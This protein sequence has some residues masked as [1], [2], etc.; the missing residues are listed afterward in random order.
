MSVFEFE[1]DE[2]KNTNFFYYKE[3]TLERANES[4]DPLRA[5]NIILTFLSHADEAFEWKAQ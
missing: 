2:I 4:A 1:R 5:T 3:N